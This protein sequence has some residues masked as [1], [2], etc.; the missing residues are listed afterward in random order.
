MFSM[1]RIYIKSDRELTDKEV[2]WVRGIFKESN[3]INE[4]LRSTFGDSYEGVNYKGQ[5]EFS[6]DGGLDK[7][8]TVIEY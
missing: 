3:C 5:H 7:I 4:S 6:F 1:N 8:V 2:S